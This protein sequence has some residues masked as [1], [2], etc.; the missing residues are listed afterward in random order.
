[1]FAE[2]ISPLMWNLIVI[3]LIW[4]IGIIIVQISK[5]SL[6]K[7]LD[8][9]ADNNNAASVTDKIVAQ[10]NR[11]KQSA[12]I[13]TIVITAISTVTLLIFVTF[14]NNS[15][16]KLESEINKIEQAPLPKSF[17]AQTAKE[18]EQLNR[19]A[20]TEKSI[21]LREK[22]IRENNKAMNDGIDIFKKAK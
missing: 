11:V 3:S 20:V 4:I 6:L 19:T 21:E 15:R 1:M 14:M 18:I 5:V 10:K 17:K 22:A 2:T 8:A 7:S 13:F 9:A 16:V 12:R